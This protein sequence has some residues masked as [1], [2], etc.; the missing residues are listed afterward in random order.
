VTI[1][2]VVPLDGGEVRIEGEEHG[3]GQPLLEGLGRMRSTSPPLRPR[4]R[5]GAQGS[6][7]RQRS[8]A[9]CRRWGSGRT[10][11]CP[12]PRGRAP[13]WVEG[14]CRGP[15]VAPEAGGGVAMAAGVDQVDALE[16]LVVPLAPAGRVFSQAAVPC[17]VGHGE[18]RRDLVRTH[19][20]W[21]ALGAARDV[22][23]P[24]LGLRLVVH[25][26]Q[27]GVGGGAGGGGRPERL[28]VESEL[29]VVGEKL[30]GRGLVPVQQDV[31]VVAAAEAALVGLDPA[32]GVTLLHEVT[33]RL[34]QAVLGDGQVRTGASGGG[35]Y[36]RG[37]R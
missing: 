4:G 28:E 37:S 15:E 6:P 32:G 18:V 14:W 31:L 5:A 17:H 2:V 35:P 7:A 9:S 36:E 16:L 22:I 27:V 30:G 11:A 24:G 19:G 3:S 1:R 23:L 8:G 10:A 26:Q 33:L 34:R 21:R 25:A 13:C 20:S 29:H 12:C